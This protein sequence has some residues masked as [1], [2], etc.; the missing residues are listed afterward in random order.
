MQP[1]RY[2][3]VGKLLPFTTKMAAIV[4]KGY[5]YLEGGI[6][7]SDLGRLYSGAILRQATTA[8]FL[9]LDRTVCHAALVLL[10]GCATWIRAKHQ[11]MVTQRTQT[12]YKINFVVHRPN[13]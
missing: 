9:C 6:L 3:W 11:N 1:S 5:S 13:S 4:F 7:S 10:C 8:L 2:S 12:G